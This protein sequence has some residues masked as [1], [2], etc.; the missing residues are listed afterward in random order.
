VYSFE[1]A[2]RTERE[3]KPRRLMARVRR[4]RYRLQLIPAMWLKLEA[5]IPESNRRIVQR[6]GRLWARLS[7]IATIIAT[8]SL[9][10][11]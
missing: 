6:D 7:I 9:H 3:E 2:T 4:R 8:A 11:S 10:H 5:A 1:L